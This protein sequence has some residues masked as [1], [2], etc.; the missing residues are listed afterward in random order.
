MGADASGTQNI[1]SRCLD[2]VDYTSS[3][4]Y[5]VLETS[6]HTF[7]YIFFAGIRDDVVDRFLGLFPQ[8][9]QISGREAMRNSIV[10]VEAS[11]FL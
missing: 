9:A 2:D 8:C 4:L 6:D 10:P 7:L 3:V 1:P 5:E 11:R